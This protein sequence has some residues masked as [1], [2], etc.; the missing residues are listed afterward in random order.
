[1]RCL[2]IEE[3]SWLLPVLFYPL[4]NRKKKLELLNSLCWSSTFEQES[5]ISSNSITIARDF[6][7]SD[8]NSSRF[9]MATSGW[10]KNWCF[11]ELL[12][13][14]WLFNSKWCE[15]F[16]SNAVILNSQ[17][18]I[19]QCFSYHNNCN[20]SNSEFRFHITLN[21]LTKLKIYTEFNELAGFLCSYKWNFVFTF[22]R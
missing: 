11:L 13:A 9:W 22:S 8:F 21:F 12:I 14:T 7:F 19:L 5:N 10:S 1:M 17:L 18:P 15:E 2:K 6:F 20:T 3:N 4:Q 16:W